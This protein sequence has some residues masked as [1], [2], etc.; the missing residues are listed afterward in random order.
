MTNSF[1]EELRHDAEENAREIAFIREKLP[2]E[3]KEKFSD[4]Q[5][6]YA[7]DAIVDYYFT[8]GALDVKPDADGF[9]DIDME[10]VARYICDRAAKDGLDGFYPD[11][12]VLIAEADMDFQEE[13]L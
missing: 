5:L 1:D 4:R 3:L 2:V 6:Q 10:A 13:N 12:M 11:E 8:S 7:M 9:V